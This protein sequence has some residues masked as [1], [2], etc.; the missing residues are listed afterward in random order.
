LRAGLKSDG[1]PLQDFVKGAVTIRCSSEKARRNSTAVI[2]RLAEIAA[3]SRNPD[4]AIW[5]HPDISASW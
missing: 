2:E 1:Y 3:F 5:Y 4:D